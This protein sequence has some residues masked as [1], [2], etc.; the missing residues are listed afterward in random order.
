M[1]YLPLENSLA[2]NLRASK[3]DDHQYK[4]S[5]VGLLLSVVDFPASMSVTEERV[6]TRIATHLI[7]S[8]L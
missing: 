1:G 4:M 8:D 5:S 6:R 7:H 2:E 3:L